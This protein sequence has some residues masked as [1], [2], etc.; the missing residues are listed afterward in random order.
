MHLAYD[1]EWVR[2]DVLGVHAQK[3]EGLFWAGA[4]V[5]AGRM[6]AADF[7]ALADAANK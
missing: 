3:Q 7:H 4:N 5:P 1:D 2:R 6:L